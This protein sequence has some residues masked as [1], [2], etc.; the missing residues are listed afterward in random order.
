MTAAKNEYTCPF[1]R[2]IEKNP[3]IPTN[4]THIVCRPIQDRVLV[5]PPVAGELPN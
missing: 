3:T 1:E 5:M 2:E 4:M